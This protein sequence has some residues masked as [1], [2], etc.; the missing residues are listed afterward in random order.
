VGLLST[1]LVG[2]DL[3]R[4][5]PSP[6]TSQRKKDFYPK[7]QNGLLHDSLGKKATLSSKQ[8][9]T[10]H[11]NLM[12][13]NSYLKRRVK[14]SYP[15]RDSETIFYMSKHTIDLGYRVPSEVE[16]VSE[17]PKKDNSSRGLSWCKEE[18]KPSP[19]GRRQE[20][21]GG[22]ILWVRRGTG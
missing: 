20:Y 10:H 1:L 14:R 9:G 19:A 5:T 7:I 4:Q 17:H 13:G 15:Q 12:R 8:A 11:G 18:R 2:H 3:N 21:L 16:S 6:I 22:N